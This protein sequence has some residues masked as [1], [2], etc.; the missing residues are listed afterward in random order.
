EAVRGELLAGRVTPGDL[1]LGRGVVEDLRLRA[2]EGAR[3]R[4]VRHEELLVP[5]FEGRRL[6]EDE[7]H[8]T[9]AV[10][11]PGG[12]AHADGR[13]L[14]RPHELRQ[15][16]SGTTPRVVVEIRRRRRPSGVLDAQRV[17]GPRRVLVGRA[18]GR[19]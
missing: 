14:D 17:R 15:L 10:L 8:E 7:R 3:A 16:A 2:D 1:A 11:R 13:L 19:D 4:D 12:E 18:F 9:L 5:L 6:A